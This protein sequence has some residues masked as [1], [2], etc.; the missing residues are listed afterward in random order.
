MEA[1]SWETQHAQQV[2]TRHGCRETKFRKK[3][4]SKSG[5]DKDF[6]CKHGLAFVATTP[7]VSILKL[8][9]NCSRGSSGSFDRVARRF[10]VM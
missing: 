6:G 2:G 5:C 4:C 9:H 10:Q 8:M 1:A 3:V 7:C